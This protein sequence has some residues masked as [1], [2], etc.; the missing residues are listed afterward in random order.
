MNGDRRRYEGGRRPRHARG[1][2]LLEIEATP[3]PGAAEPQ[4]AEDRARRGRAVQRVEVD[5]RA[6]RPQQLGA[7]QRRVGDAELGDRL[8]VAAAC[9]EL[10]REAVRQMRRAAHLGDPL[11]LVDV[12]D[13]HRCRG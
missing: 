5:A 2:R 10:P 8:V 4:R 12:D 7:L 9:L 6:P 11:D 13:R 1:R 3:A